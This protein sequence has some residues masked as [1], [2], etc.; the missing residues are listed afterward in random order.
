MHS[1]YQGGGTGR[2]LWWS[3]VATAAFVVVEFIAGLEAHSLALLSD[4]AHNLTDALA[5]LLAWFGFF[6]QAKPAN[7]IKT[8]GYH[9]AGVLT[10]FINALTIL[11]LALWIFYESYQRL[12][13]PEPVR[14][15]LMIV[16]A[17]LGLVLNGGIM[18]GLRVG[19]RND[20]N[21]RSAF[22]HMSRDFSG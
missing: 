11:V 9:R 22:A 12:Q 3:L 4:A 18:W 6:L 16:I 17:G 8:F 21:I 19:S 7:E 1:H 15:T 14:E 20:I 10:A 13:H 2:V 5:L